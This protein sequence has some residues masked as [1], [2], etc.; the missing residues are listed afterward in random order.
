MSA[1]LTV[2]AMAIE[3]ERPVRMREADQA[4][5]IA[6]ADASSEHCVDALLRRLGSAIRQTRSSG[7]STKR[8]T[9]IGNRACTVGQLAG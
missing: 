4:N 3:A 7:D 5:R 2:Y 9:D 1:H 8:R 6:L